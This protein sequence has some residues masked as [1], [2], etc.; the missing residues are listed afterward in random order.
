M[1]DKSMLQAEALKCMRHQFHDF[2]R[3]NSHN[4]ETSRSGVRQRPENV[5]HGPYFQLC[6]RGHDMLHRLVKALRKQEPNAYIFD[7]ASQLIDWHLDID[8]E[9]FHHICASTATACRS[10]SVL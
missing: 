6:P 8:A 9:R 3:R 1:N 7:C 2:G 10:I 5:K 4:L